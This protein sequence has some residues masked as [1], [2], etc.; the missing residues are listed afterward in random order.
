MNARRCMCPRRRRLQWLKPSTLRQG[1]GQQS[2]LSAATQCPSWVKLGRTQYDHMF[3]A[4]PLNSDIA[5][6][7]RHVSKGP[8]AEVTALIHQAREWHAGL[9]SRRKSHVP[10]RLH[11]RSFQLSVHP[12]QDLVGV[13]A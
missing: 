5:R 11:E 13:L 9:A 6:R 1:G 8:T 4:L 2:A 12:A 3:S 7:S 10:E